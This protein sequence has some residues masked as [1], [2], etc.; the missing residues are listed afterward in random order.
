MTAW[1]LLVLGAACVAVPAFYAAGT[2]FLAY[3]CFDACGTP[4]EITV[5]VCLAVIIALSPSVVVRVY[6]GEHPASTRGR[7]AVAACL[8]LVQAALAWCARTGVW[9]I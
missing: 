5:W 7:M 1:G 4:V 2:A 3:A 8:V 6:Q 9:P